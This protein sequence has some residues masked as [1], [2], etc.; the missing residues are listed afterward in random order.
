MPRM[1]RLG[2]LGPFDKLLARCG[3][4]RCSHVAQLDIAVLRRRFGPRLPVR[5]IGPLLRC[6]TCRHLG[7]KTERTDWKD[8]PR[9]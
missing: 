7:G 2:D 1:L 3:D 4:R 9:H 8:R 6:T 5:A